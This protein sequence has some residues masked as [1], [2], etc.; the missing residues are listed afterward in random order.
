MKT[1]VAAALTFALSAPAVADE[2]VL[3]C[4]FLGRHPRCRN[5]MGRQVARFY[6][7]R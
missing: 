3:E 5:W 7:N 2:I 6:R 4:E 1:M